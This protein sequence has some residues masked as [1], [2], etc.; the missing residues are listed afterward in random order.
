MKPCHTTFR[1]SQDRK[2]GRIDANASGSSVR[3]GTVRCAC[4]ARFEIIRGAFSDD[5][6]VGCCGAEHEI[7]MQIDVRKKRK[8]ST[9]STKEAADAAARTRMTCTD[10]IRNTDDRLVLRVLV[11]AS[12]LASHVCS[13]RT[14][15]ATVGASLSGCWL[16]YVRPLSFALGCAAS[17]PRTP[18]ALPLG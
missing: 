9:S 17:P 3:T 5:A 15:A 16:V 6:P 7:V 14:L 10:G 11:D 4:S 2:A 13:A 18:H 8:T 12:L 1:V